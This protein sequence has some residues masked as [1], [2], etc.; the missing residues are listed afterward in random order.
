MAQSTTLSSLTPP[1]P[2][3]SPPPRALFSKCT[4]TRQTT[5]SLHED[6]CSEKGSINGDDT[7]ASPKFLD[8]ATIERLG[9]Q[10]PDS[11]PSWVS[12]SFFVFTIVMSMMMSEFFIG[13]FNIV[14]PPIAD[15]LDMP[16]SSRTWPAGVTN[17]TT[18]ALLQP[19]ARLCDLY[20]GRAVFL[21]GHVWLLIWSLISGFSQ[22]T[23]MLIAC[24]AMQ[25]I[26]SAAFLPAGLAIL[27]Q[28][29]RPG[30][31]KNFVFAIYG[32]F[33]CIGFYFGIFVGA[34]TTEYL[35]WRW[36]FWVGSMVGLV[37]A[38]S[39]CISIPRNL[40]DV[41]PEAKM[42][43]LGVVTIVPGLVLVVFAFTDGGHAPD[44]WR[45]PYIYSSLILG[46]VFLAA[47]VYVQGWVSSQPLLPPDLFKA[48]YMKRLMAALFLSY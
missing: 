28:M 8:K 25:G 39:G 1:P 36:Y 3:P 48:K 38:V 15:A 18:A 43:W 33:A 21:C 42:D 32:A 9:R 30:P 31:R 34:L 13:G 29:Y 46:L 14:L 22:N 44:G 23:T 17:L 7:A 4:S 19:F 47:A 12:E 11:L 20:G 5:P 10:R 2:P 16:A 37:I 35:D 6:D 45:T 26:G 41:N 27:S 40:G 24:R